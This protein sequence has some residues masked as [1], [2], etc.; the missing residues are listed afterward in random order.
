MMMRSVLGAAA[1]RAAALRGAARVRV[2]AGLSS[3]AASGFPSV[4]NSASKFDPRKFLQSDGPH[5]DAEV[6]SMRRALLYRSRQTGWL[7][8]DLIMGR[9][10][11]ENLDKLSREELQEYGKIVQVRPTP[12][13]TPPPCLPGPRR[14][15]A[16]RGCA[17]V[18]VHAQTAVIRPGARRDVQHVRASPCAD[19][20]PLPPAM[21]LFPMSHTPPCTRW[22]NSGGLGSA[23]FWTF[24]SGLMG[25][26]RCRPRSTGPS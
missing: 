7:E 25:S 3:S 18:R 8:T 9:W 21:R 20:P 1:P 17:R 22:L 15:P 6:A 12:W 5:S 14:P 10:A 4:T 26:K 11:A 19:A 13:G 24:S 23:K 2:R 16:A